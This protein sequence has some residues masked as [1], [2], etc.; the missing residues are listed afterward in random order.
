M[1]TT[2]MALEH[3]DNN[4][5]PT[6]SLKNIVTDSNV[7]AGTLKRVGKCDLI[8]IKE[9]IMF[10]SAVALPIA[11]LVSFDWVMIFTPKFLGGLVFHEILIKN[12]N[13]ESQLTRF[14]K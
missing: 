4:V 3:A 7:S 8:E 9:I 1:V 12:T 13:A 5:K 14:A 6:I 10:F 11:N 2:S